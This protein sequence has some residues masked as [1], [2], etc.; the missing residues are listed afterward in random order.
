M[1]SVKPLLLLLTAALLAVVGALFG[2]PW[3]TGVGGGVVLGVLAVHPAVSGPAVPRSTRLL[4]QGGLVLLA[5]AGAVEIWGWAASPFGDTPPTADELI[6]LVTDPVR[7]RAQF[8]RQLAVA[9]CLILAC[10]CLGVAIGTLPGERLRRIGRA[11][12][13]VCVL[14]LVTLLFVALLPS[15]LAAGLLGSFTEVAVAALLVLGGYAWAVGR[16]IRR[17]DAA[18]S[19]VAMGTTLLAATAWL[20]TEDAWRSRPVPRD[21]DAFLSAGAIVD[22]GGGLYGTDVSVS[23]AVH[24][25]PDIETGVVVALLLLGAALTVLACARLSTADSETRRVR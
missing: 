17:H 4:L 24:T 25:G 7:Q 12:R 10:A 14:T 19:V 20:V 13:I 9:S 8:L 2:S 1:P 22:G 23:V 5:L 21:S 11:A 15:G 3:A 6:A 18:P 16:A